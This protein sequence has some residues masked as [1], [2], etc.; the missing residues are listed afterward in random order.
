MYEELLGSWG[1]WSESLEVGM[2]VELEDGVY[3]D[4]EGSVLVV[5]GG[6][7]ESLE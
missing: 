6:L 5:V 3:E 7:V 4:S 1:M 2:K